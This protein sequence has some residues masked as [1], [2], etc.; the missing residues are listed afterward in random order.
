MTSAPVLA[1]E[2]LL[3]QWI[4]TFY[5]VSVVGVGAYGY[6]YQVWD[7]FTRS[8][9]AIKVLLGNNGDLELQKRELQLHTLVSRHRNIVPL[10]GYFCRFSC[11]FLVMDFFT[12][13][14][15]FNA[16]TVDDRYKQEYEVKTVFSQI[17]DAVEH[18]HHN[19]V[20]HRDL[21]P[22]NIL[23]SE[24]GLDIYLGDFGLATQES[25]AS[26]YGCG[27]TFY[28]S[29]EALSSKC[30]QGSRY[31]TA[32]NDIW[33]LGVIL[34][35]IVCARN[36]WKLA[37]L[38][39]DT[40]LAYRLKGARLEDYLEISEELGDILDQVFELDPK[41]RISI[42]ELK[43]KI[44]SCECLR[45]HLHIPTLPLRAMDMPSTPVASSPG[46][47]SPEFSVVSLNTIMSNCSSGIFTTLQTAPTSPDLRT[48]VS[49][50]LICSNKIHSSVF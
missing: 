27:S 6:V 31:S 45:N 3:D 32:A 26:E 25:E 7:E 12:A 11:Y 23:I 16:I 5:F 1:P 33:S 19:G 29:P 8:Q 44:M 40:Y 50:N 49:T 13:G 15:L 39:D 2:D 17:L 24:S 41:K 37:S 46:C 35:N 4:D 38:E 18:C 34:V 30:R 21:K 20:Y 36:P 43:S 9:Y 22:E 28:M 48:D 10:H 47:Q 14:D 42:Q